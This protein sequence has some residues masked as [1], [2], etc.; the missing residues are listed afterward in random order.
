MLSVLR[1]RARATPDEP[2]RTSRERTATY[3]FLMMQTLH[4]V[5]KPWHTGFDTVRIILAFGHGVAGEEFLP[6]S[7]APSRTCSCQPSFNG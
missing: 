7:K 3:L 5:L 4:V 6:E 2:H 1:G